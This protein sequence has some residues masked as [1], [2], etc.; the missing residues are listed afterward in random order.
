MRY[1]GPRPLTED[2]SI[3]SDATVTVNGKLGYRVSS[4]T[5]LELIGF[6]LLNSQ[7]S[8]IDY[9]SD[10]YTFGATSSL[11]GR[12]FHPIES[13]AFRVMVISRF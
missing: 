5:K 8:A 9:Y 4:D 6:N 3:R 2:N 12:V 10:S 11:S 7:N 1:F 13:R